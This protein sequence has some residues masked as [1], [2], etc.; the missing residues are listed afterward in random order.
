MSDEDIGPC[1]SVCV[2]GYVDA[3]ARN[4]L[5]RRVAGYDVP[6]INVP[7]YKIFE[8][9]E[10][11]MYNNPDAPFVHAWWQNSNGTFVHRLRSRGEVDVSR[12]AQLFGG[13]GH[14]NAAGYQTEEAA[15][16]RRIV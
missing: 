9:L 16:E 6:S 14:K 10:R 2:D 5:I 1:S 3:V 8:V 4:A 15:R 11:V 12:I 7:G 13:G